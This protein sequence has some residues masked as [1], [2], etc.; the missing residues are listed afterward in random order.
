MTSIPAN[1][2]EIVLNGQARHVPAGLTLAALLDHL[3]IPRD[4]V[5]IEL[6]REIVGRARWEQTPVNGGAQVEVVHFVGGG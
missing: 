6:E 3:G 2:I 5:A 4:R 1:Q